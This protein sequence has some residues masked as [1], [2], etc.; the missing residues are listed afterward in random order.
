[1]KIR[2]HIISF[3]IVILGTINI[4]PQNYNFLEFNVESGLCDNFVYNAIQDDN[5]FLWLGTGLGVCR[6]DGIE[7]STQF[8]GDSLPNV[9]VK[10]S[11]IDSKGKLWF[12][13][14]NGQI[15]IYKNNSFSVIDPG[16]EL[17]S[18]IQGFTELSN[19][20]IL[21]ATQNKGLFI[22]NNDNT[23]SQIIK[24]IEGQLISSIESTDDDIILLGT[25]EG[26]F[27]YQVMPDNVSLGLLGKFDETAYINVKTIRKRKVENSFFIGT[28]DEGLFVLNVSGTDINNFRLDKIGDTPELAYLDVNDVYED[29]QN[30]IWI[31][32]G[33]TGVYKLKYLTSEDSL[34][35]SVLF[36]EDNGLISNFIYD[37]FE[38]FEGNFWFGSY[39]AGLSVL[40]NQ[41][42]SIFKLNEEIYSNNIIS[43]IQKN[44]KYWLGTE[45]GIVIT[46]FSDANPVLID[47]SNGI[48]NDLI[49]SL[50]EDEKGDVWVGTY[51]NGIYRI[52]NNSLKA[53]QYYYS[54]NSLV[55][56]INKIT[57]SAGII[58]AATNGG[59]L[60][61]NTINGRND[62]ISTVDG[63]PHNKINDIFID[64]KQNVWA[65]TRSN[66]L[67]NLIE[68]KSLAIDAQ[69]ELEF[70]SIGEDGQGTVWGVTYGDGIFGFQQDSLLYFSA[71]DGLKVN[72][73]YSIKED[74]KGNLWIGHRPGLSRLNSERT[75]VKSFGVEQGI[76]FNFNSHSI[77]TDN[78]GNLVFGS[79]DGI[80]VYDPEADIP[81][82]IPPQLNITS[83]KI[84]D[85]DYSFNEPIY[86]PYKKYKIRIDFRGINF[87]NP[88]SVKY[89]Y[90]LEGF[91]D[92]W[93][94]PVSQAFVNYSRIEDGKYIFKL[95]AC[96]ES[97]NC[98]ENPLE[99]R[100]EV[101][102]PV[103]KT[104]WFILTLIIIL[105]ITVYTI[106]KVRER[107]Q[108]QI[109]EYLQTALDERTKEVR[110]QATEIENKNRDITDS[111]N[112]AQRIQASIL[113]PIGR[114]QDTFSG[115]FVF[116]QPRDIVSGDFY[117]Y[118]TVW[119]DKFVIVCADST[120]HGVPGA[121]MSMIGT[122][123]IKDICSRPKVQSPSEILATLDKEIQDALNQNAEAE[124]SN[125]GMDI[126]VA[127]IN[128]KTNYLKIASAMR[129]IILYLNGE[130]TYVKGSR[131]SVGG[132]FDEDSD[133][134]EFNNEGFQ[135]SKGDI[136]YMFSDGYP[137]QFGGPL[138][139]KFKM[140]R[141]KNLLRDIHEKPMDEQYN[142][143]KSNFML[144]KED[145]EQVDDV[146][147]MGIKI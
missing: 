119:K 61:L 132:R 98:T 84:S 117:W 9:P 30:N 95:K 74:I 146:L 125:D 56:S 16:N 94:D 147:F 113:P 63:L 58:W 78:K 130:Q 47:N 36:S 10:Q 82:T 20:N 54:Q 42:F 124:K 140:V 85:E 28:E 45:T 49:T 5:G 106:I 143:I 64:S 89:Q 14:D 131:N 70:R 77:I 145:L 24:G 142:Y 1:L 46:D 23:I 71:A 107:K 53:Y 52:R 73:C 51:R 99:L 60:K 128:L 8:F 139:K 126:I 111:I 65:A 112:Y 83:L 79:S 27:V 25:Y 121:F 90:K 101:K 135:L 62:S 136:V 72:Y 50:F 141:L 55:N 40:K 15:A 118:D 68:K 80:L 110:E 19:G 103:W 96:D 31:S 93:S 144:W 26:L 37:I 115:S 137:D 108:R 134:K 11:F 87:K 129:P 4:Y 21:A 12:G 22:I 34:Y 35:S 75:N 17:R 69:A 59:V 116:Y 102:I 66:G 38:D 43:I 88:E 18:S 100:I 2:I 39:G 109:Q 133:Q 127:E 76:N 92:D 13:F 97:G 91:D 104:W 57:G 33:G 44:D 48:P 7:F 6:Y 3:F 123:L 41:A 138:G 120:G 105:I 81:D 114:L 67:Y 32:S 29:K 86:L 122:T